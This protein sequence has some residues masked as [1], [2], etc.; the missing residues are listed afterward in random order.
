MRKLQQAVN[1][2]VVIIT[3][4]ADPPRINVNRIYTISH[5]VSVIVSSTSGLSYTSNIT[6]LG[7]KAPTTDVLSFSLSYP[8]LREIYTKALRV[9]AST[10]WAIA[11][12]KAQFWGP[13]PQQALSTIA[14][15]VTTNKV[16]RQS[17]QDQGSANTRPRVGLSIPQVV[18]ATT[19]A[20]SV[21]S[22]E[23][24]YSSG[25]RPAVGT[26]V[27]VLQLTLSMRPEDA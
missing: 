23:V 12:H 24:L 17:A 9:S 26:F 15:N 14:L 21:V 20:H 6:V 2:A 22:A 16:M 1:N 19:E 5:Q 18:W 13:L 10:S 3:P 4:P 7:V 27:G 11:L 25:N 8:E